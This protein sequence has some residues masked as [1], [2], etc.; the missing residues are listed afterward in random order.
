VSQLYFTKFPFSLALFP[1]QISN[2]LPV[3]EKSYTHF[4]K[5][6]VPMAHFHLHN[7]LQQY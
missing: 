4:I 3:L 5:N 7:Y 2:A 1:E 6:I